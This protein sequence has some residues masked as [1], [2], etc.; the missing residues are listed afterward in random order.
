MLKGG[1]TMGSDFTKLEQ[2]LLP[3]RRPGRKPLVDRGLGRGIV[4]GLL[5]S[6]ILWFLVV[7]AV[8]AL[9]RMF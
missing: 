4:V 6:I 5:G 1:E 8:Q 7:E 9:I 3:M 2:A